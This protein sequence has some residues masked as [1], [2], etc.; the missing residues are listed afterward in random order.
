MKTET[1]YKDYIGGY[2]NGVYTVC[3]IGKDFLEV[4]D[5][6]EVLGK[7]FLV[8]NGSWHGLRGSP[9]PLDEARTI[10]PY[11]SREQYK[12]IT[13]IMVNEGSCPET[14][15]IKGREYILKELV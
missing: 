6:P 10:A 15:T 11:L 5:R 13:G 1:K 12:Q 2:N 8:W 4:E 14:V 9:I 7:P 3:I